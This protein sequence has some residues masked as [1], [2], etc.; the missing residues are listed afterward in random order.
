[1]INNTFKNALP[2]HPFVPLVQRVPV[3]HAFPINNVQT[4]ISYDRIT[5]ILFV[6]TL[7]SYFSSATSQIIL[8]LLQTPNT[9]PVIE[10]S[11]M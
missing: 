9:T 4:K 6:L 5:Q 10:C 2:D 7:T 8:F 1:M 3:V 11:R